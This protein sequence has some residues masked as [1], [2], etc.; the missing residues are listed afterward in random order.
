MQFGYNIFECSISPLESI[1]VIRCG[2]RTTI[3][4]LSIFYIITY[5]SE[6]LCSWLSAQDLCR[7]N[8][9]QIPASKSYQQNALFVIR[10]VQVRC[11][12]VRYQG[13]LF[14]S[15]L[16][17]DNCRTSKWHRV[18]SYWNYK[19]Q[20]FSLC[21]CLAALSNISFWNRNLETF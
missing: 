15:Y 3:F 6:H 14:E 12:N 16:H 10:C 7:L 21:V 1:W 4:I 20:F 18:Y 17:V 2:C 5:L 13:R 8:R 9:D 19:I 11:D